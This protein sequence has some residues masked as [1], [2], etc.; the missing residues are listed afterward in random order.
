MRRTFFTRNARITHY[1]TTYGKKIVTLRATFD[2][3]SPWCEL[4]KVRQSFTVG[5]GKFAVLGRGGTLS[6]LNN[7]NQGF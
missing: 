3:D 5:F 6:A 7:L 2:S 1:S 4:D